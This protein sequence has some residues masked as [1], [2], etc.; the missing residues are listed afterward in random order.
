MTTK[1]PH[2]FISHNKLD[3]DM[4]GMI[5]DGLSAAGFDCWI[6]ADDIPDAAAWMRE[7]EA[8]V[9]SCGAMI[10]VMTKNA[11]DSE[12]VERETLLALELR[13]PV[14]IA[15]FD[16]TPLPIHLINRQFTDFRK[17]PDQALKR[18][19]AALQKIS[20]TDPLPEPTRPAEI[21][22]QSSKPNEHNFF[23]Y[24]EQMPDGELCARIAR[25]LF[26]WTE[27]NADQVSFTGRASP[28]FHA[29]LWV[30]PGGATIFSV[31]ATKRQP[32]V[33]V[34]LGRL[35]EFAPYDQP[36]KR[37]KVLRALNRLMPSGEA[38][39]DERADKLPNLPLARALDTPASVDEFKHIISEIITEL[40]AHA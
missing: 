9:R 27:T 14:F 16:D 7:I 40:R 30:G 39:D 13:K 5:N 20:F 33:E 29:N 34:P 28:A 12:W 17:R 36:E 35:M 8:G 1:Q 38:F 11:R 31:R 10:V 2:I 26:A 32:T 19:I 24:I 21:K 25:D 4:L 23:R 37:L 3:T 22:K 18:L 6:D 15:R